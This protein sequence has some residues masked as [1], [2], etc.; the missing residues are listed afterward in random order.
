MTPLMNTRR[1]GWHWHPGAIAYKAR[2]IANTVA[3]LSK[4][5]YVIAVSPFVETYLRL[6]H[7][8][9]GEIRVI[10]NAIP[11]LPAGIRRVETFPKSGRLT[12]GC[13]GNPGPLKNIGTAMDAFLM[14]QKDLPDSR[15]VIFGQGWS[16]LGRTVSPQFYRVTWKCQTRRFPGLSRLRNRYMGSPSQN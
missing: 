8:F 3:V 1:I 13:Y 5:D 10:P 12:F 9:R 16:G 6:R 2:W 11:P 4:F 14:L 7:H 15:L